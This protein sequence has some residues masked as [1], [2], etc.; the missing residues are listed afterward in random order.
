VSSE[1]PQIQ[2]ILQVD[3]MIHEPARLAIMKILDS[4]GEADFLYLRR[5]GGFTQGNLSGHL[6][7]LEEAGYVGIEKTFKGKLPLTVCSL[8]GTG[9][10]AF[11]KYCRLIVRLLR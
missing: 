11:A 1:A 3:R 4:V 8:T 5:E 10:T 6:A 2:E 9:R 7:R